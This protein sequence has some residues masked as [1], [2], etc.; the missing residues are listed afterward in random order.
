MF[1]FDPKQKYVIPD[2]VYEY[3]EPCQS[4]G[5]QIEAAWNA[6]LEKYAEAYAEKSKE[7]KMRL[8]GKQAA[9]WADMVPSKKDLPPK[10]ALRMASG[11]MIEALVSQ[12]PS[13][14]VGSADVIKSTCV[15]WKGMT[16]FQ[17]VGRRSRR[18][19]TAPDR[20]RF[21]AGRWQG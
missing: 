13:F 15:A 2:E 6:V 11:L 7:L 8:E 9:G 12:N 20:N 4:R 10:L 17:R 14:M 5:N 19:T 1:G 3:F 16:E 21:L 18:I